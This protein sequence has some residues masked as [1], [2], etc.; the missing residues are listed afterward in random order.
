MQESEI[1]LG[2][3]PVLGS[4]QPAVA[5][6]MAQRRV[7][8]R[9]PPHSIRFCMCTCG[10]ISGTRWPIVAFMGKQ[11]VPMLARLDAAAEVTDRP[12]NNLLR[13]LDRAAFAL[14]EPHLA[15]VQTR[16]ND[17]LY[18]P[19]ANVETVYFPCGPCLVSFVVPNEDGRDVETILVGREG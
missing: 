13:R 17:L 5:S 7:P 15:Q 10:H 11:G 4:G 2:L 18:S 19:G 12:Y 1:G 6:R 3:G 9:K 14:I 8:M 16:A